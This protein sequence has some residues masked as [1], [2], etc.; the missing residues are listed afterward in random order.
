MIVEEVSAHEKA[1]CAMGVESNCVGS[2]C[3]AWR[4]DREETSRNA[5]GYGIKNSTTHGFC[6]LAGRP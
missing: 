2:R 4:W 5:N 6:G 1:C 3:M